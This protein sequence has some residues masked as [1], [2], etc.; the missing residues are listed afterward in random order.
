MPAPRKWASNSCSLTGGYRSL[1]GYIVAGTMLTH[2]A[3][4]EEVHLVEVEVFVP[5][6]HL[7]GREGA[8]HVAREVDVAPHRLLGTLHP[9]ELMS[10]RSLTWFRPFATSG[11]QFSK[12]W[13]PLKDYNHSV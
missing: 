5:A 13:S 2:R 1:T 7:I 3:A 10:V 6:E 9:G 11:C 12:S 8:L 4:H